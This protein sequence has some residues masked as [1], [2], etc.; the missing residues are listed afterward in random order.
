MNLKRMPVL[1][2]D[3]WAI[4]RGCVCDRGVSLRVRLC[5][6]VVVGV[7]VAYVRRCGSG[8]CVSRTVCAWTWCPEFR[9]ERLMSLLSRPAVAGWRPPGAGCHVGC[10]ARCQCKAYGPPRPTRDKHLQI[11]MR[12]KRLQ[13][14]RDTSS[15]AMHSKPFRNVNAIR[16]P[17]ECKSE[18]STFG[19]QIDTMRKPLLC[20]SK[21]CTSYAWASK[22]C[23]RETQ[24]NP[25]ARICT[26]NTNPSTM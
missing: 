7:T 9:G 25:N 11:Q 21:Q 18:Q 26:A 17:L 19:L 14:Q 3:V 1:L 23:G 20:T 8:L 6:E 24:W 4:L 13:I 2:G 16:Q 10:Q 5:E 22:A 12:Y 15:S